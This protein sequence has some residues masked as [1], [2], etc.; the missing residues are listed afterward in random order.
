MINLPIAH[1]DGNYY[2]DQDTLRELIAN[3]Q[4]VFKYDSNPNGSID[5]IAGIINKQGNVLG[6]MPH[7]ERAV[8]A[9]L[10]SDDGKGVFQSIV[11][12]IKSRGVIYE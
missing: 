11:N 12:H 9:V 10:G 1:G 4:I 5:N 6:M 2:C 3:D 8:E 7:P